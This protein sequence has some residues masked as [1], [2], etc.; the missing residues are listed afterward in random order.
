MLKI[1]ILRSQTT[2]KYT[3]MSLSNHRYFNDRYEH[4]QYHNT[5]VIDR[6]HKYN[7]KIFFFLI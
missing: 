6:V 4:R 5:D 2:E 7:I 3:S 1:C